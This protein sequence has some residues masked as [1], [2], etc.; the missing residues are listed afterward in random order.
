MDDKQ[1]NSIE[2]EIERAREGVSQ[3]I[4]ELDRKLRTQLDV[5]SLAS[6]HAEQ[7]MAGGAVV[8][9][10]VGFGFPKILKRAI[11]IGVPLALVAYKV[12][13]SLN[14]PGSDSYA[15]I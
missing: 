10:L 1:K 11:Q 7:L 4:D 12:R 5:K 8:G 15:E 14:S 2:T 13:Q 3:H 6:E 9:F